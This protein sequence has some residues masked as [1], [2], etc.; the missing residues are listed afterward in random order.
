V[1]KYG[2]V[3]YQ[4]HITTALHE[5]KKQI[6]VSLGQL[7]VKKIVHERNIGSTDIFYF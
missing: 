2:V 6:S 4:S 3:R 7:T 1:T 5:V